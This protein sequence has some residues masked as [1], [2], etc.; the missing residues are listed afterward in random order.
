[1]GKQGFYQIAMINRG[2]FLITIVPLKLFRCA[3]SDAGEEF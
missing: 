1:M 2:D 3:T